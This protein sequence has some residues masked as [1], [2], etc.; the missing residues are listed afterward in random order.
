M[1]LKRIEVDTGTGKSEGIYRAVREYTGKVKVK[2]RTGTEKEC[3]VKTI[4]MY[5]KNKII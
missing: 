1:K 4:G 5:R 3:I 2:E